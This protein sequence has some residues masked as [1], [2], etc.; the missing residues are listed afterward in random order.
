MDRDQMD[1]WS[2]DHLK[3]VVDRRLGVLVTQA[4]TTPEV[5][6]AAMR[7]S[8]LAPGKRLRPLLA[9]LTSFHFGV[10]D[11]V[12][13]DAAC[14]LE[15]IH[16]ASLIMDD[17]PA[18]DNSELRRGLPTAHRKFGEE[19]AILAGIALLN[20][21]YGVIGQAG[22]LSDTARVGLM[23]AFARAIGAEGLVGGQVI[24]LRERP[25]DMPPH[26]IEQ[27]NEMKTAALFVAA[28][29]TGAIIAGAEGRSLDAARTFAT[30]LGLAFQI[31]DDMLD[32]PSFAGTTGKDTGKDAGKPTVVSTLGRAEARKVLD[33]YLTEARLALTTMSA[34]K[35]PL[36]VFFDASFATARPSAHG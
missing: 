18:M 28:V 17:L 12:A 5:L 13:L 11:L 32:D 21:A 25:S 22:R 2:I 6:S 4:E 10:K 27:L 36:T 29:E 7:Y 31:A 20:Q 3:T 30:K 34:T 9:L 26:R 16:A 15:M 14:A 19:I 24:D 35:S 23:R 8:L 1:I 33:R